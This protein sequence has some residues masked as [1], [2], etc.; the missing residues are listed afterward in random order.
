MKQVDSWV[1]CSVCSWFVHGDRGRGAIMDITIENVS[2]IHFLIYINFKIHIVNIN[3][4]S[5]DLLLVTTL[6]LNIIYCSHRRA[7]K[8]PY[9]KSVARPHYAHSHV[10]LQSNMWTLYMTIY[11]NMVIF[12]LKLHGPMISKYFKTKAI[13]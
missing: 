11:N 2:S 8:Q 12:Y 1:G 10:N 6:V 7:L 3:P 9:R 13:T 4:Y 5:Q